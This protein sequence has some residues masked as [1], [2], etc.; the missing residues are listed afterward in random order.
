M[1]AKNNKDTDIKQKIIDSALE[2]AA[3]QGWEF[4]TLRDIATHAKIKPAVLYDI[5]DHKGDILILLG[6]MIDR[7]VLEDISISED[8][9]SSPRDRL[10]DIMMDRYEILNEYKEG[11]ISILE[12]NKCDPKHIIISF[13]YL[14]RSMSWMLE[15]VGIETEGMKGALKIAGLSGVYIKVL[16]VWENDDSAD[17]SKTMAALDKALESVE[18]TADIL[19]F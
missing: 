12:F 10:F 15:S 2:L 18:K 3:E 13:P 14:C 9:A 17:L 4:V 11:L 7:R 8:D 19:G 5:I 1:S 6:K 16:K